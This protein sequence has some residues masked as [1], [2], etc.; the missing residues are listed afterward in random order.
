MNELL[1]SEITSDEKSLLQALNLVEEF[2]FEEKTAS[3]QTLLAPIIEQCNAVVV[4][5]EEPLQKAEVLINELYVNHLMLDIKRSSW[6]VLGYQCNKGFEHRLMA[7]MIKAA[8]LCHIIQ[9]CDFNA[10]IVFIPDQ[11]MVRIE[12]DD[13]YAIIFD[14]VTGESISWQE[15]DNRL[16]E[17]EGDPLEYNIPSI[18]IQTAVM[19]YISALKTSLI[20]ELVFDKALKCVDILLALRPDDPFERRDRGFLLH[21]L[22]CFKVAYDDYK[23]FV[24]S[25]PKDPAAQ[26]L[27]MQLENI[28]I[29]TP[30]IH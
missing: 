23:F 30:I 7:P 9:G 18:D 13:V 5:I 1:L 3:M 16:E 2:I 11:V 29:S 24:E 21:Q 14:P 6:P 12:C 28:K 17:V 25:C 27:K 20:K 26:L 19:E 4:E 10:D 15:L 8:V 22:D